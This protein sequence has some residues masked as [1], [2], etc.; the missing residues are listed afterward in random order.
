MPFF[1]VGRLFRSPGTEPELSS[2]SARVP[3]ARVLQLGLL[4]ILGT[5]GILVILGCLAHL[6]RKYLILAQS[7]Q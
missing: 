4:G 6:F 7:T 3:H 2:Y 5:L 1:G